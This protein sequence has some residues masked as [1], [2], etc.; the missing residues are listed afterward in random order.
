MYDVNILTIVALNCRFV[1]VYDSS[2]S[3]S[4]PSLDFCCRIHVSAGLLAP[5]SKVFCVTISNGLCTMEMMM[6]ESEKI[7]NEICN[8][9]VATIIMSTHEHLPT[10]SHN[11]HIAIVHSS[12]VQ[13]LHWVASRTFTRCYSFLCIFRL[14]LIFC[15]CCCFIFTVV[16]DQRCSCCL[17]LLVFSSLLHSIFVCSCV[18]AIFRITLTSFLSVLQLSNCCFSAF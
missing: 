17:C 2:S 16:L 9:P 11:N 7:R 15:C 18:R 14:I 1:V 5:D 3:S 6:I 12:S 13:P 10:A 8:K 4:F